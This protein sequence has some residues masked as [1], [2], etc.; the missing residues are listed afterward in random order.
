MEQD[1]QTNLLGECAIGT[2]HPTNLTS[3]SGLSTNFITAV[4]MS[5]T[6]VAAGAWSFFRVYETETP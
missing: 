6:N 5:F 4:P 1:R 2:H 3:W